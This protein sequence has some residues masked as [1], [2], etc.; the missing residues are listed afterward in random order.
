[1]EIREVRRQLLT[2]SP[3]VMRAQNPSRQAVGK[4]RRWWWVWQEGKTQGLEVVVGVDQ[5]VRA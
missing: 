4:D 3:K 2:V 1:M 5:E